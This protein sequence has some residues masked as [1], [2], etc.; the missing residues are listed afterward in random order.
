M[1]TWLLRTPEGK[2]DW[3]YL[4]YLVGT[5]TTLPLIAAGLFVVV[6]IM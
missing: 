1:T 6:G 3:L 4:A 2:I 5:M